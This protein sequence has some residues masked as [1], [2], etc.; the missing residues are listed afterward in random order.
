MRMD[1]LYKSAGACEAVDHAGHSCLKI[2]AR[3][4][5]DGVAVAAFCEAHAERERLGYE[6]VSVDRPLG[7]ALVAHVGILHCY[8]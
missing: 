7:L 5:R 3:V 1:G 2:V 8:A 6:I 4:Y